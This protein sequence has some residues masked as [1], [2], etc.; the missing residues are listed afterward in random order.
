MHEAQVGLR[1]YLAEGSGIIQKVDPFVGA[2]QATESF[3]AAEGKYPEKHLNFITSTE[4]H[5]AL[6]VIPPS[7]NS[8]REEEPCESSSISL[9]SEKCSKKLR[10]L[11]SNANKK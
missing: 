4:A 6:R 9:F 1:R 11:E 3:H 10:N 5:F 7:R 2:T 8:R